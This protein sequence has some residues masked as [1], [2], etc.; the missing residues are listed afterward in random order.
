MRCVGIVI[1]R[2]GYRGGGELV[3]ILPQGQ[4]GKG[5][6]M[7]YTHTYIHTCTWYTRIY[8]SYYD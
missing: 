3:Y 6:D 2:V 1:V 5:T 7:I 8:R 4:G